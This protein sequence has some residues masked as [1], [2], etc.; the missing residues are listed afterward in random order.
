MFAAD[1]SINFPSAIARS[2][3]EFSFAIL[4]V[5]AANCS[6]MNLVCKRSSV[7]AGADRA[8]FSN[9]SY[10]LMPTDDLW[11]LFSALGRDRLDGLV[12]VWHKDGQ[13]AGTGR[14]SRSIE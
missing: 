5:I 3:F 1:N 2:I 11:P 6:G 10:E 14:Q 13:V 7:V 12:A 4:A 8:A 9:L